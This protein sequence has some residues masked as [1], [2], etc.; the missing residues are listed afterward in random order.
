MRRRDISRALVA[1]AAGA[2]VLFTER[3]L[4][5]T[6]APPH[7]AQTAAER[8]AAIVPVD[9]TLLPGRPDR[10]L[11]NTHPG[12]TD[13][14][15]GFA[16]ACEQARQ[17]GGAAVLIASELALASDFALPPGVP[18]LF[19]GTGGINI[20]AGATLTLSGYVGG[21]RITVFTGEGKV[22]F[23]QS[24]QPEVYPEW[25]GAR[26]DSRPN[27]EGGFTSVGTDSTVAIAECIL[28]A[29]GGAKLN[30]GVIPIR[31]G[32]GYYMTGNQT[33]PPA[34]VIRG[35]GRET[36][37][38]IAKSGTAGA[39]SGASS[40]AWFTDSGNAAKIILEDFALYA[41]HAECPQMSYALRLGYNGAPHGT[42]G[43]L[44]NLRIRDCACYRYGFHCD[45]LGNVG[46][47]ERIATYCN[48]RYQ[49][50]GLRIQGS[51]NMCSMLTSVS[52][53]SPAPLP[54]TTDTDYPVN[55]YAAIR[56]AYYRCLRAHRANTA[57]APPHS[58]YW[59]R[60][61]YSGRTYGVVLN[62]LAIQV[63]GMEIEA[64]SSHAIPL[65]I[66]NN[67]DI[68]GVLFSLADAALR[69]AW[70]EIGTLDHVWELGPSATTWKLTGASYAFAPAATARI[71][72][73]NAQRAD[74]TYFGGN[75]TGKGCVTAWARTA[76]YVPGNL[77][78][79]AGVAYL[80]L[81]ENRDERPP[82]LGFWSVFHL[83]PHSGEGNWHSETA[84]QRLQSFT[85]RIANVRGELQHRIAE[86]GGAAT[87][88]AATI[89]GASAAF[90]TTPAGA[91]DSTA[92][93]AGGKIGSVSRSTFWLDT[94]NQ[95]IA[96]TIGVAFV[97]FNSTG[98]PLNV[99]AAIRAARIGGEM[100]NRLC[101][102]LTHA[103]TG[104]PFALAPANFG[105]AGGNA[106]VQISW[107][108]S[109]SE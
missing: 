107:M 97:S 95:A 89:H 86:P 25:W 20:A 94:A 49:Q 90:T 19:S 76:A 40:G 11:E 63:Q 105:G 44:Q 106:A 8:A 93:A 48:N 16:R 2:G 92:F 70:T 27:V 54:W 41:C 4:A 13:M 7:Y 91:D 18:L 15:Q 46:Y 109:I 30:V 42:E 96:D 98:T 34:T 68:N 5:Q 82:N 32:N 61:P 1:S 73:G 33:L 88:F 37:G 39:P 65:S 104:E 24:A 62:G 43:Y 101:F 22:A 52:A 79:D 3:A 87:R 10:Y 66:Q 84:G 103:A 47:Y 85:L 100:R 58:G 29:A 102:E 21:P 81:R 53:G 51:A 31:I 69:P 45:V 56:G 50:S 67:A 74:G 23:T 64:V 38:F 75:A 14:Q 77:V 72:S 83:A 57:N 80:C 17:A 28:A 59:E 35:N 108:G 12:T 71:L 26:G 6:N 78:S 9:D 99:M 60:H 55:S 36:C